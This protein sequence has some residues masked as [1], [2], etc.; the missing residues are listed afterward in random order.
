MAGLD[1]LWLGL[2]N[3]GMAGP[4]M[5]GLVQLDMARQTVAELAQLWLGLTSCGWA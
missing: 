4:T 2:T 5:A 3:C 1:Q